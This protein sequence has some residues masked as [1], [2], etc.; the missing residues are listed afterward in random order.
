MSDA[1]P[2]GGSGSDTEKIWIHD[3]GEI[4]AIGDG[5]GIGT[6]AGLRQTECTEPFTAQKLRQENDCQYR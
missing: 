3:C 5:C 2:G 6:G 4:R 1:L